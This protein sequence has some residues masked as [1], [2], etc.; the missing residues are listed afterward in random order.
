MQMAHLRVKLVALIIEF[1][2]S[3]LAK[4]GRFSIRDLVLTFWNCCRCRE[5]KSNA[6]NYKFHKAA[7]GQAYA[8][9]ARELVHVGM[10]SQ[11][12]YYR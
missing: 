10:M 1:E 12:Q 4:I 9:T 6:I 2:F 5:S 3:V 11:L 7:L 8:H